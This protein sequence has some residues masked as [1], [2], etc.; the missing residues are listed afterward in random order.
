MSTRRCVDALDSFPVGTCCTLD[1]GTFMG[2]KTTCDD[3]NSNGTADVCE[4]AQT[5]ACCL[6][7]VSYCQVLPE[8]SCESLGGLYIGD[9][10][11]CGVQTCPAQ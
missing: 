8:C 10:T 4:G 6:F 3:C 5:G 9:N 7:D 1:G 2:D 11:T